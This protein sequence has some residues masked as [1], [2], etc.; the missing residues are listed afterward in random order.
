MTVHFLVISF[1]SLYLSFPLTEKRPKR[2]ND[3]TDNEPIMMMILFQVSLFLNVYLQ[4]R[5]TSLICVSIS[6]CVYICN[7]SYKIQ[8]QMTDSQCNHR[9]QNTRCVS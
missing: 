1:T 5:L 4:D 7:K 8:V 3:E 2:E 6:I 9:N